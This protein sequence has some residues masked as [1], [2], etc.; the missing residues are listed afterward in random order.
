MQRRRSARPQ[1]RPAAPAGRLGDPRAGRG[2]AEPPP[3]GAAAPLG[4]SPAPQIRAR[5]DTRTATGC[6]GCGPSPPRAPC[7]AR[8]GRRGPA[9]P[10]PGVR[11]SGAQRAC[12]GGGWRAARRAGRARGGA[13]PRRGVGAQRGTDRPP[14]GAAPRL[15][16]TRRVGRDRASPKRGF[17]GRGAQV[18]FLLVSLRGRV[19]RFCGLLVN[20]PRGSNYRATFCSAGALPCGFR[21]CCGRCVCPRRTQSSAA[22][23]LKNAVSCRDALF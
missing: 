9:L 4:R 12:A 23:L 20:R 14:A 15:S 10:C 3:R 6:G 16:D 22:F 18:R 7:G 2:P 21:G 17:P 8:A 1:R 13:A 5:T 19:G 11:G